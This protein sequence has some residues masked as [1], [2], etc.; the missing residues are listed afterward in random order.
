MRAKGRVILIVL[1]S[2]GVGALPDAADYGDAGSNT[3]AHI[4]AEVPGM[5]LT[6]M[7]AMGLGRV[8][9]CE[10]LRRD[11]DDATGANGAYG[12]LAEASAGK[13]TTV[14]HWEIAGI[15]KETPFPTYPNGFPASVIEAFEARTGRKSIGNVPASGTAIIEDFGPRHQRTGEIIVYTSA[16]SVFQIAAHEAVVP[17]D[18]LYRICAVAREVL[19]GEHA[20]A[21]VIAR[22]FAGGDGKYIRTEN[23]RD[24][25]M[26]PPGPTLLDD[27]KDAGLV[28][29]AVGKIEDIFV[30]QGVTAA[31]HTKDNGDGVDQTLMQ[32]GEVGDG[33]IFTNLVDFDMRYGH[34]NDTKGYADALQYFDGRLPEIMSA[35]RPDDVLMIT[36]DHGCDPTFPGTDHTREYVPF[37]AWGNSVRPGADIGERSSFA[38]IGATVREILGVRSSG[39]GTG[40]WKEIMK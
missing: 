9:G 15:V 17:V 3:L 33:L 23:R 26:P 10:A 6:N 19:R 18:E 31:V 36:A 2:V 20:V 24:Y 30:G 13:D 16:D 21:R 27:L 5:R 14:G 25:S 12:R 29:S 40:F 32:M 34:R 4:A 1:D 38:D 11:G 28:V 8:P 22:P 39:K 7:L 37:L 35:M